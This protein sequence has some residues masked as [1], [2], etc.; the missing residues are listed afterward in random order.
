M[1][2]RERE[3]KE[4]RREREKREERERKERRRE[5]ERE[6]R[7]KGRER[8][9]EREERGKRERERWGWGMRRGRGRRG[10]KGGGDNV[11]RRGI[12]YSGIDYP[13]DNLLRG[14]IYFVTPDQ[15]RL[16]ETV[17]GPLQARDKSV[18]TSLHCGNVL[19]PWMHKLLIL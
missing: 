11:F 8:E 19:C 4:R 12:N 13:G 17:L 7:D 10:K 14:I 5:R 3:R 1:R 18:S 9:R 6:E 15:N 16:P 2:E